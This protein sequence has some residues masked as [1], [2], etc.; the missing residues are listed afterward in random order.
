MAIRDTT[1][2]RSG[3]AREGEELEAFARSLGAEIY[4]V[5]TADAFNEFPDK[6]QPSKFVPDARS[7]IVIGMPNTRE[8]YATVAKPE[9][10]EIF[11][12]GADD[13][14]LSEK[15][16]GR[17]PAGAEQFY[18]GDEV[19][20]LTHEVG[21]IGYKIAWKLHKEGFQAFYFPAP[22][23]QEP[24]FRTAPFYFMPAMYL[25]GIGQMGLNCSILTP[26]YGPRIWV[27]AIITNKELPANQLIG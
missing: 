23:K 1:G 24:R 11:R 15:H 5:A 7:V 10:A 6:P 3:N 21:L 25:A 19:T 14:A 22:F 27:T 8:I 20:L 17:P 26:D 4:G 18:L 12:T 16:L 9:L 2:P 13:V